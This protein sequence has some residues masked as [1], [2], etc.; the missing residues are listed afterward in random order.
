MDTSPDDEGLTDQVLRAE[1]SRRG[2]PTTGTSAELQARLQTA[3]D[4]TARLQTALCSLLADSRGGD[5][6]SALADDVVAFSGAACS[7]PAQATRG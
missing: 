2:L 3:L 7:N 5:A 6:I 1:L 4:A